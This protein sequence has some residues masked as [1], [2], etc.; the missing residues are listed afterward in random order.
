MK[1]RKFVDTARLYAA[2]GNGG[3]GCVSFRREKY[4]PKGGPNGGDGGRGGSVILRADPDVDSLIAIF[5]APH[6]R[7]GHADHG[8]GSD[9]TGAGGKDCILRVPCG[10]EVR[11]HETQVLLADLVEPGQEICVARGGDGGLGNA[12]FTT[13]QN[14]A[15]RESTPGV[16]G[17][18]VTLDLTLKLAA[19]VGLVGYPNAGKSS[20]LTMVSHAHPKVAAYPFTT[21]NPILGTHVFEDYTRIRIADIPGL[22]EDAHRGVGLG[23]AFLRHVERARIIVYVIDMAGTD[24][25][26]PWD[27]YISLFNELELYDATIVGRPHLVVANKMDVEV[28]AENLERFRAETGK[29]A[30]P[31]SA[32]TGEGVHDFEVAL[33]KLCG[34]TGPLPAADRGR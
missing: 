17:E 19:D 20:L 5:Y 24:G 6:Q 29:Q 1:S 11:E 31:L 30:L 10:T 4:V 22:I 3:N 33:A 8:Q 2:A 34:K 25:R 16:K 26:E 27:D 15:P 18:K 14:R 23:H 32:A 9:K 7:A 13:S 21:L 28:A 12:H